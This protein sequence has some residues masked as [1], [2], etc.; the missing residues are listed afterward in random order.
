MAFDNHEFFNSVIKLCFV[1]NI[2]AYNLGPKV[3]LKSTIL[4]AT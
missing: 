3:D 2:L 1:L 4:I